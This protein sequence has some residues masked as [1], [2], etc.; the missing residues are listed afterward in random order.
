MKLRA[1]PS[2][3]VLIAVGGWLLIVSPFGASQSGG[4]Y[5]LR[6]ADI[7][8]GGTAVSS[9]DYQVS[10]TLGQP[11]TE[12]NSAGG[13]SLRGGFWHAQAGAQ[14]DALFASGFEN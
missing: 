12:L 8:G 2:C 1:H 5:Q 13:Y 7:N 3:R 4:A 10:G 6:G 11:A 9:T 14:S